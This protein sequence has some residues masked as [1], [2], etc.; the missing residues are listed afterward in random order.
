M[1]LTT[2]HT[3]RP[4]PSVVWL[5]ICFVGDLWLARWLICGSVRRCEIYSQCLIQP[6]T[7]TVKIWLEVPGGRSLLAS[8]LQPEDERRRTPGATLL[9][10]SVK[11][12]PRRT[13]TTTGRR[14]TGQPVVGD[15]QV[16][17]SV[18]CGD[19][20]DGD[21]NGTGF[22]TT[23]DDAIDHRQRRQL[24]FHGDKTALV[25]DKSMAFKWVAE[26][27]L[28]LNQRKLYAS[29]G[30]ENTLRSKSTWIT[31]KPAQQL[32]SIL[33][34]DVVDMYDRLLAPYGFVRVQWLRVLTACGYV[35]CW[36]SSRESG[37]ADLFRAWSKHKAPTHALFVRVLVW[38][39]CL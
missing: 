16:R 28:L 26:W 6:G 23:E 4:R 8:L 34:D 25:V 22:P 30:N 1:L 18:D 9:H 17:P 24:F 21:N 32:A 29:L 11:G 33:T 10:G 31:L 19:E 35:S 3:P 36:Q 39:V 2:A 37:V 14:H 38:F 12:T 13:E 27:Q 7:D 5:V 20:N 15:R